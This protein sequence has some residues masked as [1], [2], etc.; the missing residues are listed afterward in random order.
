MLLDRPSGPEVGCW[1]EN[2]P[3]PALRATPPSR[4]GSFFPFA[5]D[6]TVL[7]SEATPYRSGYGT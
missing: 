4:T 1:V 2:R 3:T 5:R 6:S 7:F